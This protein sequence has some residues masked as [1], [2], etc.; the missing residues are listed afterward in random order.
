MM[1][2]YANGLTRQHTQYSLDGQ[3]AHHLINVLRLKSGQIV[4]LTNGRGLAAKCRL[5]S[6]SKKEAV[7]SIENRFFLER[8]YHQEITLGV[9]LLK[10]RDRMEWLIEKATEIGV[11][12]LCFME[13]NR[14]ERSK[15][16]MDRM[17]LQSI[18]AMKQ[19]LQTWVPEIS[20]QNID[21]L[22]QNFVNC[23]STNTNNELPAETVHETIN[24]QVNQSPNQITDSDEKMDYDTTS[25]SDKPLILIA[26]ESGKSHIRNFSEQIN[27]VR[28]ILL[29]VGPEGGFTEDELAKVVKSGGII[30]GL[31]QN[32]LRT[33]TAAL[34][35]LQ[36]THFITTADLNRPGVGLYEL[37]G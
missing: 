16:R 26:H 36:Y 31:G 28:R 35:L 30:V 17:Q 34:T 6:S 18:S 33:E 13:T 10:N 22:I 27:S 24:F 1:L 14:S 8:S 7:F 2:F 12:R 23:Q 32:R 29:L 21:G 20:Q 4:W 25:E 37:N 9:G 3:E 15:I 5:E 19:S 11:N